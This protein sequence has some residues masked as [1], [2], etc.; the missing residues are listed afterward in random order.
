MPDGRVGEL[1]KG[2]GVL[3]AD[4]GTTL[5]LQH[6]KAYTDDLRR[7]LLQARTGLP[8]YVTGQPAIQHDLDP[9]LASDLR[10]GEALALPAALL[11]LLAVLG[12]SLAVAIPFVVAACTITVSLAA[13]YAFAGVTPV[14]T[15]VP[16]LVELIGL[17]L[18]VDYSLLIVYRYREELARGLPVPEAIVEDRAR[19]PAA[20]SS[21]P[22]AAVAI[23]LGLLL[24][25]A[26]PVHALDG[27][28][29]LRDSARVGRGGA[30][31]P[32]GAALAPR[33]SR[34]SACAGGGARAAP[35][36][37]LGAAPER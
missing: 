17:G 26:D 3:Y 16:N 1:R 18:A 15:Y 29:R 7:A 25:H 28:R 23:G 30:H 14:V 35:A 9:I 10:R 32:A 27:P 36:A 34:R 5:D 20:P 6:A 37:A 4:V 11:V 22:G 2:G 13:V 24:T 31:A 33:P 19:R 21:S 8:T 12:L